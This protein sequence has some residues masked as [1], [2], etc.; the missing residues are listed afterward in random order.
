M[1]C[2][3]Y[4]NDF[5]TNFSGSFTAVE[6]RS[7][8]TVVPASTTIPVLPAFPTRVNAVL[9]FLNPKSLKIFTTCPP[10]LDARLKTLPPT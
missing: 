6:T 1:N 4:V 7:V 9:V 8:P 3:P 10:P 2:V 5:S